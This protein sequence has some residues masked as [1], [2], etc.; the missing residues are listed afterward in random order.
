MGAC[1]VAREALTDRLTVALKAQGRHRLV[2]VEYVVGGH[3]GHR[4]AGRAPRRPVSRRSV[5][6]GWRGH[7]AA[8]QPFGG[9]SVPRPA[10]SG[11][12]RGH[13]L[14]STMRIVSNLTGGIA[15]AALLAVSA[16]PV[17]ARGH[18]DGPRSRHHHH[19]DRG[20]SAG[21]VIGTIAAVGLLAAIASAASRKKDEAADRRYDDAPSYPDERYD[22]RHDDAPHYDGRAGGSRYD[23]GR[24]DAAGQDAAVDAC[25]VAAR[26]EASRGGD[27]A[28]ILG[29][30]GVG[31]LGNGW[32]V[33]GRVEQRQSYR[34]ADGWTRN[35][36]CAFQNGRISAVSLD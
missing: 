2:A 17:S 9:R 20:P 26:D 10:H 35:F 18:W 16:A 3:A 29:V 12:A 19:H 32:D 21:A 11:P 4:G 24:E 27:Y 13:R 1:V 36:R 6:G 30:T 7:S 31:R 28:E 34:A 14:G 22:E 23:P 33:S 5:N 15:V 8:A 25:V